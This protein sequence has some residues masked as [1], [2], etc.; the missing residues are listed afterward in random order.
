MRERGVTAAVIEVSSH[1]LTQRRVDGFTFDLV[2][3]TQF[4]SDHLDF[5]QD[6]ESYFQA[7]LALFTPT[8]ARAGIVCIDGEG[9]LRLHREATVPVRSL[10]TTERPADWQVETV[11]ALD[12]GGYQFRLRG[13]SELSTTL[14]VG[15]P[16][17]FNV[18]NAALAAAMLHHV[19]LAPEDIASGLAACPGVPGRMERVPNTR[20]VLAVVDYAHTPDALAAILSSLRVDCLGRLIVVVGCGGDRDVTKRAPMGRIAAELAD[21][22]ILTDDNP[23]SE[24]AASIRQA[25][26]AGSQ[27]VP[28]ARRATVLEVPGRGRGVEEAAKRAQPGDV[29][30]VAGKGHESGQ[31][32]ADRTQPFD[33]RQVLA[34]ALGEQS[35]E[36]P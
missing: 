19:G 25:M 9:G 2:G 6:I 27:Q 32:L 16:G 8:H 34:A 14:Q 26:L 23:R 35:K 17:R 5:H 10:S 20:D 13:P 28:L 18:S 21:V 22:A 36:R 29:V 3:F 7:K 31:E 1:A 30:L 11:Q 15:M 4:G 24:D 12:A 33:D